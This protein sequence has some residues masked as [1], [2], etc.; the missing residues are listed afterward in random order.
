MSAGCEHHYGHGH[1]LAAAH[2]AERKGEKRR[3]LLTIGLTG[4]VL[5]GEVVGGLVSRSLSLLSDAGHMFSDTVAQILSLLAL[6]AASRPSDDRRTYGWYRVEILAALAN[7][8]VLIFLAAAI[9]WS[10]VGRLRAP[11]EIKT[12]V[13]LTVAGVGL[14]ANLI[15]VALLHGARSLNAR[16]AYLHIL[17]DT[18]SSVAVLLGGLIIHLRP[19]LGRID[20]LLSILL[21][22]FILYAAYRLVRDAVDVLLEAVP[23]GLDLA[24]L[25]HALDQTAGIA[26]VHDLHV[27][28]ISSGLTALS[29][30]I[31]LCESHRGQGDALL[32][33]V[34]QML[35]S[36]FQIT[37]T[38]LQIENEGFDHGCQPC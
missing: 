6:I 19:S 33:D 5:V 16:G 10:A 12:G 24:E 38:T 26:A 17:L 8:L 37:H 15:G 30:H 22:L 14:V 29:A 20:P 3:L 23:R 35:A 9:L 13:M 1:G 7:G 27:W 31:V 36:R 2:K 28:T 25:T 11:V 34:K 21:G 32:Y 18:L 4:L